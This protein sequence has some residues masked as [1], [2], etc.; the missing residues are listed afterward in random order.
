MKGISHFV[1]KPMVFLDIANI[2][3]KIAGLLRRH[4]KIRSNLKLNQ[5]IGL[6]L[7]IYIYIYRK[8]ICIYTSIYMYICIIIHI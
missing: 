5:S 1:Q 4:A 6:E 8:N 3:A 2:R 7:Y